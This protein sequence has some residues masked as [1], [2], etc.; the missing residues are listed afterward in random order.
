[1]TLGAQWMTLG[2]QTRSALENSPR[3][4]KDILPNASLEGWSRAAI[5]VTGQVTG[6]QWRREGDLLVCTGDK[7][8]E[9]LYTDQEYGDAILHVE[10]R[11]VVQPGEPRY[12]SGVFVR[13]LPDS[14]RWYQAQIGASAGGYLFGVGDEAGQPKRFNLMKQLTDQRVKPAGEWNVLEVIAKGPKLTLWVNG[15]VTSEVDQIAIPKGRIG[16]EAEG[17]R[18]EFRNLKLKQLD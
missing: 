11:Y 14:S 5:P 10:F 4:W 17:F 8:H 16:L 15:G 13:T 7:G 9:M 12:N 6:L 3:G 2:A 18:I 1:L